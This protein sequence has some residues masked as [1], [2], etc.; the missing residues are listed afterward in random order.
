MRHTGKTPSNWIRCITTSVRKIKEKYDID[1]YK[2]ITI[3]TIIYKIWGTV[4]ANKLKPYLHFHT[5]ELQNAYKDG[6]SAI[7]VLYILNKQI[8]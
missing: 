3:T 6:R 7:D 5:G 1:N 8:F 4:I 2:P